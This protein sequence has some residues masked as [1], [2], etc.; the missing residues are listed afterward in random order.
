MRRPTI[1]DVSTQEGGSN[2]T[3]SKNHGKEEQRSV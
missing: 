3:P 1:K 2:D